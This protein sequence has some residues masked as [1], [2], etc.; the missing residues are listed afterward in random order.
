MAQEVRSVEEVNEQLASLSA[1]ILPD[2]IRLYFAGIDEL[3]EQDVNP[4]SMP[5]GMFDQ[6]VDNVKTS[7][8]L[9]SV[10][11]C[12]KTAKGI[13]II[14]GHHRV[15]AARE[16]GQTHVLILLY[17]ELAP[18]R[19]FSKQIAHN[20]ISG[21]ADPELVR[22][23]FE[24]IIEVQ[25]QYEAY[26]DPRVLKVVPDP[27]KFI[28]VDIDLDA[29]SRTVLITFLSSQVA[30]FEQALEAVK[31]MLPKLELDLVVIGDLSAYDLWREA[32]LR[33][34]SELEVASV[35]AALG[36]MAR[37]ALEALDAREKAG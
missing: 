34:R 26:V 20:T 36:A 28:S 17:L 29:L 24:Q 8:V 18:S 15:R 10:P 19:V 30:D 6:L 37:L 14:S 11:L 25:A 13:E 31:I 16:A 22:R 2:N 33:V 27:V 7:G 9:E 5:Q 23:V 32:F 4:Q 21:V 12:V 3:I 1:L 35:P